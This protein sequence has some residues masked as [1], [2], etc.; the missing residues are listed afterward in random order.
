M[1]DERADRPAA[2]PLVPSPAARDELERVIVRDDGALG[3]VWRRTREGQTPEQIQVARGT[4]RPN[5]VWNYRRMATAILD[6]DLPTAS[7]V[8]GAAAGAFGRVLKSRELSPEARS[9]LEH[10]LQI[11]R[12]RAAGEPGAA[13][14]RPPA[15][16]TDPVLDAVAHLQMSPQGSGYAPH[17]PLLLLLTLSH[18]AGAASVERLSPFSDIRARFE[19]A[20]RAVV[21]DGAA[22]AEEPFWRLQREGVLWEM[23]EGTALGWPEQRTPPSPSSLTDAGARGGFPEALYARVVGQPKFRAQLASAL[24]DRLDPPLRS[25]AVEA[26]GLR[27]LGIHSDEF[28]DVPPALPRRS[29]LEQLQRDTLWPADDLQDHDPSDGALGARQLPFPPPVCRMDPEGLSP[30]SIS[31]RLPTPPTAH[32]RAREAA[33][34]PCHGHLPID[35]L[36]FGLRL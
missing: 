35:L 7:T 9:L 28:S 31:P 23:P 6:G 27:E 34:S 17:K 16:P 22:S 36:L 25:R 18:T 12:D 29:S 13:P 14:A 3:D 24:L 33:A 10:N 11:L 2:T 4:H 20:I 1:S 5:F 26:L 30:G 19:E 32:A 15:I 8:A 21:G